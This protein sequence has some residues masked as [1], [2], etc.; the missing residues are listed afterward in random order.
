M[1]TSGSVEDNADQPG[2]NRLNPLRE[3]IY[4]SN[5]NAVKP[6]FLTFWMS[7]THP[8]ARAQA[9]RMLPLLMAATSLL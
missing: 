7:L 5:V 6:A 4:F 9:R 1:L 3:I 8:W 2:P